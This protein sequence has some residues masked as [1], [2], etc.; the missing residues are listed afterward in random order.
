MRYTWGMLTFV[1]DELLTMNS[2]FPAKLALIIALICAAPVIG[3]DNPLKPVE[4]SVEDVSQLSTSFRYIEP[5]LLQPSGFDQV[6]RYSGRTDF[7]VRIDGATHAVFPRSTYVPSRQGDIA[8]IPPGTVFYIGDQ[9]LQ[10]TINGNI[11]PSAQ[12]QELSNDKFSGRLMWRV[13]P[14][15]NRPSHHITR[16][17]GTNSVPVVD[18]SAADYRSMSRLKESDAPDI[19]TNSIY[20]SDRIRALMKSAADAAKKRSEDTG[21]S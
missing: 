8:T 21:S 18:P 12:S 9:L 16:T 7:F 15:I 4:Q 13:L 19:V 2:N 5:G 1:A 20:R 17:I 14:Q 3:Q 11:P 6:Y 10:S